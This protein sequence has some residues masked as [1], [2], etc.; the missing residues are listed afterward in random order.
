MKRAHR[1]E[2]HATSS[3]VTGSAGSDQSYLLM[4]KD[5]RMSENSNILKLPESSTLIR[6]SDGTA[7][8]KLSDSATMQGSVVDDLDLAADSHLVNFL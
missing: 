5:L 8:L 1:N 4:D 2:L 7:M 6:I 3:G